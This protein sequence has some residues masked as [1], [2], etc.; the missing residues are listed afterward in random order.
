MVSAWVRNAAKTYILFKKAREIARHL[1]YESPGNEYDD[2]SAYFSYTPA[3][4]KGLKFQEG[5]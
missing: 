2:L 3:S 1:T 5:K 4:K